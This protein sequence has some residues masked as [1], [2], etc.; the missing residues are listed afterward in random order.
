LHYFADIQKPPLRTRARRAIRKQPATA[1]LMESQ[2]T[3]S[4]FSS[5][6]VDDAHFEVPAGFKQVQPQT[7]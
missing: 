6:P 4:N 5:A 1:I 3:I 2:T 7:R